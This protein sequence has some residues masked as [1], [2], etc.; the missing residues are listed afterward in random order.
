MGSLWVPDKPAGAGKVVDGG[1]QW[2]TAGS[3]GRSVVGGRVRQIAV[4][5]GG[6]HCGKQGLLGGEYFCT[7]RKGEVRVTDGW[8]HVV[9]SHGALEAAAALKSTR[10]GRR[11][12]RGAPASVRKETGNSL[13]FTVSLKAYSFSG[14]M[15]EEAQSAADFGSPGH[16]TSCSPF[17][18]LMYPY[19]LLTQTFC[20]CYVYCSVS[21]ASFCFF[22]LFHPVLI[23]SLPMP[24]TAPRLPTK[25]LLRQ[26]KTAA[27]CSFLDSV[28]GRGGHYKAPR[29]QRRSEGR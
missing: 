6:R 11:V 10:G 13:F 5:G 28:R 27:I 21:G 7:I 4:G 18:A 19:S 12:C 22:P 1:R 8:W 2:R 24:Y 9:Q 16:H 15:V 20:P 29:G 26:G 23:P 17:L 25:V 3:D 14:N